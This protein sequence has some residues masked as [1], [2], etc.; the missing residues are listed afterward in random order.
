MGNV[1]I[2]NGNKY[3]SCL[4]CYSKPFYDHNG[5]VIGESVIEVCFIK[6]HFRGI[7]KGGNR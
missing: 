1:F 6:R 5:K 4:K 2:A 3:F 7:S